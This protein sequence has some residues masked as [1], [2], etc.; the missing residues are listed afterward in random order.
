M[1]SLRIL[2]LTPPTPHRRLT[3]FSETFHFNQNVTRL[4]YLTPRVGQKYSRKFRSIFGFLRPKQFI[5]RVRFKWLGLFPV[6]PQ[7]RAFQQWVS[8]TKKYRA[9]ALSL[10]LHTAAN[11]VHPPVMSKQ[12]LW[13][14]CTRQFPRSRNRLKFLLFRHKVFNYTT[15]KIPQ[16]NLTERRY[17][18]RW[19]DDLRTGYTLRTYPMMVPNMDTVSTYNWKEI[20]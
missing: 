3:V 19:G 20:N 9:E 18:V 10:A 6:N 16:Y 1:K 7:P 2:P 11:P 12:A 5:T 15:P 4:F 8:A 17:T 13:K 14:S